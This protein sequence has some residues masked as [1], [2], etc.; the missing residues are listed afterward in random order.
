MLS[1][2][3]PD[4]VRRIGYALCPSYR[5][6]LDRV[7]RVFHYIKTGLLRKIVCLLLGGNLDSDDTSH[8][9]IRQ[10]DTTPTTVKQSVL[11]AGP[12]TPPPSEI[13]VHPA[14]TVWI[15]FEDHQTVS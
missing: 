15:K 10:A 8:R 1:Q 3:Y 5:Y 12:A 2:Y 13:Y 11:E 7:R 4:I 9:T 14:I 6:P